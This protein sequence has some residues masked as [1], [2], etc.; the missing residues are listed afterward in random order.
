MNL[1]V[2][3]KKI[4]NSIEVIM[5]VTYHYVIIYIMHYRSTLNMGFVNKRPSKK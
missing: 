2:K 1:E 5:Y 4:L 3:N